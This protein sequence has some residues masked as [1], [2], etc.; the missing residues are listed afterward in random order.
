MPKLRET[1]IEIIEANIQQL[2][3]MD[4]GEFTDVDTEEASA[5]ILAAFKAHIEGCEKPENPY[6]E[7]SHRLAPLTEMSNISNLRLSQLTTKEEA[8]EFS[9]I[10]SA[11]ARHGAFNATIDAD[12]QALMESLE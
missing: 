12:R 3:S 5:Q 2:P 7:L 8:W 9:N 1:I 4:I 11:T 6:P 10:N